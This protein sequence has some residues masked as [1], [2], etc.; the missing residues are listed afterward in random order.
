MFHH[1]EDELRGRNTDETKRNRK[2]VGVSLS[3]V[4]G[5]DPYPGSPMLDVGEAPPWSGAAAN[6]SPYQDPAW[7]SMAADDKRDLGYGGYDER[8]SGRLGFRQR[9]ESVPQ[10]TRGRCGVKFW[11]R[12]K[13][14]VAECVRR[15]DR[16]C[17]RGEGGGASLLAKDALASKLAMEGETTE[18]Y[19]ESSGGA[20]REKFVLNILIRSMCACTAF[21][22]V[23]LGQLICPTEH[24][25]SVSELASHSFEFSPNNVYTS[26]SALC[27][28]VDGGV[29][30]Y[31]TFST[32]NNTDLNAM[33]HNFRFSTNDSRP[34]FESMVQMIARVGFLGVTPKDIHQCANNGSSIGIYNG[35]VYD[36][37]S[38]VQGQRGLGPAPGTNAPND[39]DKDFMSDVVVNIFKFK[40]G[41]MSPRTSTA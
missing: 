29:S 41:G 15:Q 4:P 1:L 2:Q 30:P 37:T 26:V 39:V 33:Y 13:R 3:I 16:W 34:Y 19:K 11:E 9:T 7:T 40:A 27:N 25:F 17:G 28:G 20:W 18:R 14:A 31:V 10:R 12:V 8:G 22:I 35:L 32:T 23:A 6:N 5:G 38:Y 21:V 24:V 36:L